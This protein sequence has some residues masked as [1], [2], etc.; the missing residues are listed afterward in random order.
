MKV[1]LGLALL[2]VLSG[3]A[4][5]SN[6]CHER[7]VVCASVSALVVAGIV[8]SVSDGDD[9]K[10]APPANK[11]PSLSLVSDTRLKRDIRY[12]ETLPNGIR[13]HTFR[14]WNDPRVFVG[15]M[16]QEL[17]QDAR[18]RHAVHETA[19]GY[20]RVDLTALGLRMDG[21]VEQYLEAGEAAL[22]EAAPV[23]GS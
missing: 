15:V 21:A 23:A 18:Y 10:S 16:A 19:E 1:L 4:S 17:L 6:Y 3:C 14:Y 11:P 13:L 2:V 20:Y 8:M 5:V 22:Q 7:P 9:D 12:A